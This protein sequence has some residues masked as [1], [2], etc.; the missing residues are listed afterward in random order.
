VSTPK[1]LTVLVGAIGLKIVVD[2]VVKP[3]DLAGLI[4][5]KSTTW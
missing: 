3:R 2:T 5:E 1:E 4:P